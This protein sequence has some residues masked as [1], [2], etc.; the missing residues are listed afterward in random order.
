MSEPYS[1]ELLELGRTV[2]IKN[3]IPFQEGVMFQL[4]API[5]RPGRISNAS[6]D[7]C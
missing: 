6:S 7:G 1:N 5:L 3:K 2:A 4:Q